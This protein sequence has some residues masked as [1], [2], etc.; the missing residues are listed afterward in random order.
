MGGEQKNLFYSPLRLIKFLVDLVHQFNL[1]N[2]NAAWE[3]GLIIM[4]G[5]TDWALAWQ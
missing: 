4:M 1:E 3:A 5:I 2:I